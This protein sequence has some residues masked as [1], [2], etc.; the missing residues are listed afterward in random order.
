MKNLLILTGILFVVLTASCQNSKN[1]KKPLM[2]V[3]IEE[4]INKLEQIN[5][6]DFS[7]QVKYIK[8]EN[9]K[10][11]SIGD[12]PVFDI[13][14]NL[15]LMS[16]MGL[17]MV[18]F[19][20]SGNFIRKF[21]TKGRGPQE[22]LSL[23]NLCFGIDRNIYFS[24]GNDLITF[25]INGSFLK[26]YSGILSV[27]PNSILNNWLMINDSMIFG[28][29]ENSSG[30]AK[31]KALLINKHGNILHAYP[32]YQLLNGRR[33]RIVC[34]FSQ[35]FKFN[36]SLF[37]KEQFNDT[38]F[39]LSTDYR[40]IPYCSF[41]LGGLKMPTRVRENFY[42][43]F[44]K[45]YGYCAIEDI[46]QTKDY[47]IL[48]VNFGNRFPAR[49]LTPNITESEPAI[50]AWTN[51]TFCLGIY[52][53]KS[54]ELKFCKPT[55]TD[56]PLFTTGLYNN[57]DA[58]PRFFPRK[59]INDSTLAMTITA[60]ELKEHVASNDFRNNEPKYPEKKKQLEEFAN[61]LDEFD[62]PILMLVFFKSK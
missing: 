45:L 29:I 41:N 39:Y 50:M 6:S 55:S 12:Y 59:M 60:K 57:I 44:E 33:S 54:S 13:S 48:K 10:D 43:Y 1:L 21:G 56:N 35:I 58:G 31:N 32:N 42:E 40:L 61:S 47:L 5:L 25:S 14:G 23:N 26:K 52:N 9:R 36:D 30:N 51:T 22:F 2:T 7:D 15:I 34:G 18:L 27:E 3:E 38:L 28:N 16:D 62:N 19:D 8:I 53:K 11:I 17:S 49:R 20:I 46:F 24:S 37:F 4:N